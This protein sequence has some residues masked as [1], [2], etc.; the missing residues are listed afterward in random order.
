MQRQQEPVA[1]VRRRWWRGLRQERVLRRL[2]LVLVA[3]VLATAFLLRGH[4]PD[5]RSVGYPAL[6]LV[7]VFS[8]ASVVVPLPGIAVVCTAGVV[9]S[10]LAVGLVAGVGMALGELTA[11]MAGFGGRGLAQ[12]AGQ[13][14][15]RVQ[16]WMEHRGTLVLLVL[17]LV[18]NPAF[19]VAGIAAGALRYPL[20][21]FL[22]VV[23]IGKIVKGLAIAYGC[24]M[25]LQGLERFLQ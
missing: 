23:G 10:P 12:R 8:S 4:L 14:Y 20:W 9:L 21:R 11:Y 17:A 19:D 7:S 25:G 18:P 16:W 13:R 5:V 15:E 3:V 6:F 2:A 24:S 1:E 22:V